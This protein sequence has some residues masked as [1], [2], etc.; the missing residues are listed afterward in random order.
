[1][2]KT[3][4]SGALIMAALMAAPAVASAQ[5]GADDEAV[6]SR[7]EVRVWRIWARD[8]ERAHRAWDREQHRDFSAWRE[9]QREDFRA[10]HERERTGAVPADD[11][12]GSFIDDPNRYNAA[13]APRSRF[14]GRR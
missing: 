14:G 1:M 10:F 6:A 3:M 7:A 13:P 4:I 8:R 5:S 12:D 2:K 9:S 11:L